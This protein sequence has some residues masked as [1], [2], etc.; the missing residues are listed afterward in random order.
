[1]LARAIL[2]KEN[3]KIS[4]SYVSVILKKFVQWRLVNAFK[5][6]N[7]KGRCRGRQLSYCISA[8][9]RPILE[10]DLQDIH[11]LHAAFLDMIVPIR[12]E[13]LASYWRS[14]ILFVD[15]P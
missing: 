11:F 9:A 13:F 6:E 8:E 3:M 4:R 1:L 14:D 7:V 15:M 10:K 5:P 2:L 12:D